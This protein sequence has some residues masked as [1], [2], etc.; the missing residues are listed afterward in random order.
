[1]ISI[2]DDDDDDDDDD[3]ENDDDDDDDDYYYYYI[4]VIVIIPCYDF[5]VKIL[6]FIWLSQDGKSYQSNC[7][8]GFIF[9]MVLNKTMKIHCK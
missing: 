8:K 1:M 6:T 3:D 9:K 4:H 5:S 2:S 7:C